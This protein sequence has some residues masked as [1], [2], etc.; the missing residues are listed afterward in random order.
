MYVTCYVFLFNFTPP[1][2][3]DMND[4]LTEIKYVGFTSRLKRLSDELLYSTKELYK[5]EGLDIEPNWNL[6][7]RLLQEREQMT[8]TEMAE[9]LKFSHPAVV[10]IVNQMKKQGYISST[11][12]AVDQRKYNLTLTEK[13]HAHIEKFENYWRAGTEVIKDIMEDS[14]H[15]LEEFLNIEQKLNKSNYKERVLEILEKNEHL[16]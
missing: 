8:V 1:N 11:R 15:F 5:S 2:A 14:P 6:I 13:A 16:H 9:T 7:F 4:F 10:K 3:T 12:D